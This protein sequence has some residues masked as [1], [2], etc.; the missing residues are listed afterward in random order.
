MKLLK[1]IPLLIAI[2][3]ILQIGS[4]HTAESDAPT[5]GSAPVNSLAAIM[6]AREKLLASASSDINEF[7]TNLAAY[8]DLTMT[9]NSARS[10]EDPLH[11]VLRLGGNA[12]IDTIKQK[13]G[14]L[15]YFGAWPKEYTAVPIP[16]INAFDL[17][18]DASRYPNQQER[19]DLIRLLMWNE[20]TEKKFVAENQSQ[21]NALVKQ[22]PVK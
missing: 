1:Q 6:R 10:D 11:T 18:K 15:M 3:A 4:L 21:I 17:V 19:D 5:E 12:P 13:V 16:Y 2:A 20:E 8:E 9:I 7:V 22:Y 14:W